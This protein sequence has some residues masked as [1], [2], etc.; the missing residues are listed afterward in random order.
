MARIKRRRRADGGIN[1]RY[2]TRMMKLGH[3]KPCTL[4][5]YRRSYELHLSTTFGRMVFTEIQPLDIEDWMVEQQGPPSTGKSI[6]NRNRH[7]LLFP[8]V[9]HGQ[10][11]LGLL[12]PACAGVS[13]PPY[14]RATSRSQ[15]ARPHGSM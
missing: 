11:R 1:Y 8:I 14:G 2:Q 13:S 15:T 10:K 9:T 6:R 4:H 7:G 5:R 12:P 3:L